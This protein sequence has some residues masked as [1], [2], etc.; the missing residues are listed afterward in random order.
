[1]QLEEFI[2]YI[3]KSGCNIRLYKNLDTVKGCAGYFEAKTTPRISA[4]I[5]YLRPVY[6]MELIAHEYC[7][8][9]QYMDEKDLDVEEVDMCKIHEQWLAGK[10]FSTEVIKETRDLMLTHEWDADRRAMELS[11][12]LNLEP[13]DMNAYMRGSMSYLLTMKWSWE[14]RQSYEG[15]P[16]RWKFKPITLTE[17]ELLAPMTTD[18]TRKMDKLMRV[19]N[20]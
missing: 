1:M 3:R 15:T 12:K 2:K 17:E 5:K 13:W 10:D 18:E 16:S 8:Y 4:A 14:T 7:H 11:K 20:R 19:V 9:L 6:Q